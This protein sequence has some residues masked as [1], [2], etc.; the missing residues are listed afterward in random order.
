MLQSINRTLDLSP[1]LNDGKESRDTSYN[2][3]ER[4]TESKES[5]V[6]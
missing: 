6:R 4:E 2:R 3:V 5:V 1:G